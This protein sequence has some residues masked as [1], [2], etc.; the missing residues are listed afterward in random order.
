MVVG[1][2]VALLR[3]LMVVDL[4]VV[5]AIRRLALSSRPVW[6]VAAEVAVARRPAQ[7]SSHPHRAQIIV[8]WLMQVS[9]VTI[10][11]RVAQSRPLCRLL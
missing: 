5:V 6:V 7:V 9:C 8:G 11:V 3:H 1:L 4:A 2:V 10:Q